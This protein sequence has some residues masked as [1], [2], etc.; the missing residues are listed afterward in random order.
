MIGGSPSAV[1]ANVQDCDIKVREFELHSYNY[2]HFQTNTLRKGNA[3]LYTPSNG[4]NSTTIVLQQGWLWL[5]IPHEGLYAI[6]HRN[7]I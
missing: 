1:V 3:T 2:V 4:L 7:Y 6:K 5:E